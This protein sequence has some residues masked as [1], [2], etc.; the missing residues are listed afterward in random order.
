MIGGSW[1]KVTS[2]Q[3]QEQVRK[4][5]CEFDEQHK[6]VTLSTTATTG[7]GAGSKKAKTARSLNTMADGGEVS[8]ITHP[9]EACSEKRKIA[10]V[11]AGKIDKSVGPSAATQ[12]DV[13]FEMTFPGELYQYWH[14]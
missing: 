9:A 5:W 10:P 2:E 1:V 13:I 3:E 11:K 6:E 7:M 8:L 4:T 14:H 12:A